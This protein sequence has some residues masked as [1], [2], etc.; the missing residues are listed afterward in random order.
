[1]RAYIQLRNLTR[2][3]HKKEA[4]DAEVVRARLRGS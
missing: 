1:M 3:C 2:E 4:A